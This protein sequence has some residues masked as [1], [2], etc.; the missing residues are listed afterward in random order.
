FWSQSFCL[1]TAGGAP[2]TVL[3]QYIESQGEKSE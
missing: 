3:K 2:L 1:I